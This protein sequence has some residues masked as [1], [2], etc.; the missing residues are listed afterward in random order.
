M[1]DLKTK[2]LFYIVNG[3]KDDNVC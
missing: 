3:V 2:R 1:L